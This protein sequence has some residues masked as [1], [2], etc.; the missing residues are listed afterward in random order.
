VVL[1]SLARQELCARAP[2]GC[3]QL[4]VGVNLAVSESIFLT[5]V[6]VAQQSTRLGAVSAGLTWMTEHGS[7]IA[8]SQSSNGLDDIEIVGDEPRGGS[9]IPTAAGPLQIGIPP[10]TIKDSLA[11]GL[12]MPQYYVLPPETFH[13]ELGTGLGINVVEFEFPAYYNFFLRSRTIKLVVRS[14][15][16][17]Q[18][19]RAVLQETLFG[20]ERIDPEADFSARV[21]HD[22]RPDLVA[23]TGYFRVFDGNVLTLDSLVTFIHLDAQGY[24]A[25][26]GEG[27]HAGARIEIYHRPSNGGE[28]V[29][30][31]VITASGARR[32]AVVSQFVDLPDVL[33]FHPEPT[34]S[35]FT[36]PA[37][38]VTVL[39]NS[40]G[41]DPGGSTSGYVLWINRRGYMIDPPPYASVILRNFNIRPR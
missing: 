16:A 17:E 20:P 10:E 22:Q 8:S 4:C 30:E 40:H 15:E 31:E 9:Y 29:V 41:F 38:G 14:K 13:R 18:R 24:A 7:S 28:F 11:L 27:A 3:S 5:V 33:P 1:R 26:Q 23:E 6:V 19:I 37:F 39:G 34:N 2:A 12:P 35:E 32:R 25:I 21:P 36:P